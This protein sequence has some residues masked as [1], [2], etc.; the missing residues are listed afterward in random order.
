MFDQRLGCLQP[1]MP[2]EVEHFIE[3]IQTMMAS[4]IKLIIY[5]K[6]HYNCGTPIWK[7][8]KAAWDEIF[9]IGASFGLCTEQ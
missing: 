6:L 8:H 7:K 9:K 4:S 2:A 5:E 1:R 3:S